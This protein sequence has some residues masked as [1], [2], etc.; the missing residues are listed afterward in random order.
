MSEDAPAT[1]S[2]VSAGPPPAIRLFLAARF[3]S[4]AATQTQAV[5]VGW[6]VYAL[7][8]SALD[9]GFIGLAQFLPTAGLALVAGHIIDRYPRRRVLMTALTV[10][11]LCSVGLA[12]LALSGGTRVD[13]IF[14]LIA[15]FGAAR[16]FD[17]PTMASLLPNLVEPVVFPRAAAWSSVSGQA[18]VI[19]GPAMGGL[20]YLAGTAVPF[21]AAAALIATSFSCIA[22]LAVPRVSRAGAPLS[23]RNLL[24]GIHFIWRHDAVRGAISL[25]LFGVLFGGATALL[26]IFAR[27]ILAVG[28]AGLGLLRSAPALGA[29]ATGLILTRRPPQHHVGRRM[30]LAVA[31]FGA[32][33]VVFGLS[34]NPALSFAALVAIGAADMVSVV[35]RSTLIQTSTPDAIRGRV[36]AVNTLFIGTSNQLG[37]FESGVTAA[38]LG[39]VGSVVGGGLITLLIAALWIRRFPALWRMDRFATAPEDG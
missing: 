21:L 9:L 4:T 25:D 8:N 15:G 35:V 11:A 13:L 32:A 2:H 30:L 18:A 17:H 29:L 27:D 34:R 24:G 6:Y 33:T 20:L 10:E 28:P 23:W 26:P 22:A 3:A 5:A 36:N 37:E 7:T 39:P 12:A 1:P 19:L 14:L 38:W 16:A 31:A